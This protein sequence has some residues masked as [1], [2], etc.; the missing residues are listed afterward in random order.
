MVQ[1]NTSCL[2]ANS[3]DASAVLKLSP[4]AMI[5]TNVKT[6]RLKLD[7]EMQKQT[8]YWYEESN[9]RKNMPNLH[10]LVVPS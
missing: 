9:F 2:L 6:M 4:R 7:T 10:F 1:N 8:T 3:L 5:D